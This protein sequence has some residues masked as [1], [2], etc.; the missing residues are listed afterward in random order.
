MPAGQYICLTCHGS[1]HAN[2][3][4][5]DRI[6]FRPRVESSS[7][8]KSYTGTPPLR[9]CRADSDSMVTLFVLSCT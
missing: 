9:A 2:V 6:R 3:R 4:T 7:Y 5:E 1:A 8:R